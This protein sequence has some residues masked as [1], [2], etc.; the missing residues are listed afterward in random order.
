MA[1]I[2][3]IAIFSDNPAELAAFY[4]DCFGMKITG[5]SQGDVWVTDGYV[6]V[7]LIS[8]KYEGAPKGIHHWGFTFESAEEKDEVYA[9]LVA[10]GLPPKDPRAE[11]PEIDRPYVEDA[12]FDID[13]NRY[14]LT[15]AKRDMDEEKRRT[16]ERMKTLQTAK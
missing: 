2:K 7:A 6:D 9:K 4:T 12:G 15:S 3:H 14:D 1:K 11:R 5:Q 8:R 13:G 16:A 10:R